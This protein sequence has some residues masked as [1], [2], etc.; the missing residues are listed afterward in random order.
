MNKDIEA[1]VKGCKVCQRTTTSMQAKATP[2][3]PNI[4]LT[5]PWTHISID[6]ITGLPESNRYDALLVI[7]DHF[8]KAIIPV[9]CNTELSAKGWAQILRD[10]V[11]A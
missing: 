6:M 11:Y 9:T 5:E 10:H 3:H 8:S 2:L 1:Y 4:V 7:V